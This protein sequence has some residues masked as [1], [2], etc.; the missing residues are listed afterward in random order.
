VRLADGQTI[1]YE[2][3]HWP[4][5]IRRLV[6]AMSVASRYGLWS[7]APA[8]AGQA[9]PYEGFYLE[10]QDTHGTPFLAIFNYWRGTHVGGGQW[11]SSESLLPFATL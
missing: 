6:E 2:P 1:T 3:L 11:A 9:G 10:A 4:S 5:A 7:L 8:E